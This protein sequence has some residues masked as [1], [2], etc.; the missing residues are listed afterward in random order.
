MM[1]S[2]C[3]H[4]QANMFLLLSISNDMQARHRAATG[5]VAATAGAAMVAMVAMAVATVGV[6]ARAAPI[7][8]R[9]HVI[10]GRDPL[11]CLEYLLNV[12]GILNLFF[13]FEF[14]S[15]QQSSQPLW[16]SLALSSLMQITMSSLFCCFIIYLLF[17]IS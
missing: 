1:A 12:P 6:V 3:D 2:F 8:A 16:I 7:A 4:R 10:A 14:P 15:E 13:L 5:V 11:W 17:H 9:A